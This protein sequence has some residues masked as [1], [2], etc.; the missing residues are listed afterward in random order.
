[1]RLSVSMIVKNEEACLQRC[2]ESI[3]DAD[4]IVILDTGSEDRTGEI[5]KRYTAKYYENE[6]R[7]NDNFA[8]ARNYSLSKCTGDWI[9][10]IDADEVLVNNDITGI[11]KEIE[12]TNNNAI[13]VLVGYSNKSSSWWSP[14]IFKRQKDIFWKGA[15]HNYLCNVNYG[16][17]PLKIIVH[18]SLAHVKDPNRTMRILEKEVAKKPNLIRE[19]YYLGKEYWYKRDW[20]KAIHWLKRYLSKGGWA[21]ERADA[22]LILARSLWNL[23]HGEEARKACISAVMINADFKEAIEFM[24]YISGPK[25]KDRW[26]EFA[27]TA[28]SENV[29]FDRTIKEKPAKYYDD[30]F[31]KDFDSK[32]YH[33]IFEK[34]SQLASGKIL[35]IGCGTAELQNYISSDRYYGFDIS[36]V[37]IARARNPHAWQ[38]NAYDPKN[39]RDEFNTYIA[40]EVFEHLDDIRI[41]K[42][43][44]KRKNIIFS[45]PSFPDRS[46]LRMYTEN[47][48]RRRFNSLIDIEKVIR[49]NWHGGWIN[50]KPDTNDYILLVKGIKI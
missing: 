8:E 37:A 50:K 35:D 19:L 13:G 28:S 31:A 36:K 5:A 2:L 4:E 39:Y 47:A 40:L 18:S 29:L 34:A 38:S 45:V 46:H 48:I 14:R 27:E 22:F 43:I 17:S 26:L 9:F 33:H 25:N 10:I 11:K 30:I 1:M 23:S 3:K 20:A 44:P 42:N 16:K 15:V 32:R 12:K 7:W 41:I 21:A 6:Y 24:A 49:Y